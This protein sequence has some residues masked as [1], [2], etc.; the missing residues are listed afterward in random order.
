MTAV[1]PPEL[2]LRPLGPDDVDELVRILRT[3]DV[4][5]W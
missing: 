2:E 1:T 4:A 5:R 3:P